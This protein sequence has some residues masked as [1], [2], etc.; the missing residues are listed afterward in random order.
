MVL[1]VK[2]DGQ[3]GDTCLLTYQTVTYLSRKYFKPYLRDLTAEF[4][5]EQ[6]A[7]LCIK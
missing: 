2:L 3:K 6:K 1:I 5:M 7:L 4:N